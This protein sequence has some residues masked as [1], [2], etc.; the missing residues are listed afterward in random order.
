MTII[1][2]TAGTVV[3][4]SLETTKNVSCTANA[5][6]SIVVFATGNSFSSA[7][8]VLINGVASNGVDLSYQTN[9][10]RLAIA[11]VIASAGVNT[12]PVVFSQGVY[13]HAIAIPFANCA[14]LNIGVDIPKTATGSSVN[15]ATGNSNVLSN[16]NSLILPAFG[17][18]GTTFGSGTSPPNTGY[19]NVFSDLTNTYSP[20][21]F[22]YKVVSAT[23]AQAADLGTIT[24]TSAWGAGLLI[25][26]EAASGQGALLSNYRNRLVR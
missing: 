3:H 6:D 1:P 7:T 23:T 26:P 14:T 5:G 13:G 24:P 21:V 22:S 12:I 19:T 20:A 2:G 18:S 9:I 17:G 15:P 11:V 16:A 25:I 8:T 10:A 4:Y